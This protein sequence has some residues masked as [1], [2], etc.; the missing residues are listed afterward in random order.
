LAKKMCIHIH[1]ILLYMIR[2][3]AICL[4]PYLHMHMHK[5]RYKNQAICRLI[6]EALIG[7]KTRCVRHP[8][9]KNPITGHNL[10]L[11][12]YYEPW[13]LALEYNGEQHYKYVPRFHKEKYSAYDGKVVSGM[14]HF[15]LQVFRDEVKKS[16]C[17]QNGITL[18]IV[19]YTIPKHKMVTYILGKLHMAGVRTTI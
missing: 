8:L 9:I 13:K 15:E 7:H 12:C 1:D 19:P 3:I 4:I 6:L 14:R 11:D 2:V 18:I 17:D 16:L 10:E 5:E